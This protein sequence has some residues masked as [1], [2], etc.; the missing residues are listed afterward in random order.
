VAAKVAPLESALIA[1]C[2]AEAAEHRD[3]H[4]RYR[5][6]AVPMLVVA[7]REGVVRAGFVGAVTEEELRGAVGG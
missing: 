2:E 7:D 4:T 6:E 1:T 5:I 3:L